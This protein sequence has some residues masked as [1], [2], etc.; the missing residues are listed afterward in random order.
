[1]PK[2]YIW[3]YVKQTV[4]GIGKYKLRSGSLWEFFCLFFFCGR[5]RRKR[6]E[7]GER[8]P[9]VGKPDVACGQPHFRIS[10]TVYVRDRRRG[11]IRKGNDIC[12]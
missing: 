11:E 7:G 9:D 2:Y 8:G 10:S 6:K 3:K 12:F 1:M 5:E 4:H